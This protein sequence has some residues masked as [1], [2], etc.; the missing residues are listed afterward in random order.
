MNLSQSSKYSIIATPMKPGGT[1]RTIRNLFMDG[2][3]LNGFDSMW[4]LWDYTESIEKMEA[5]YFLINKSSEYLLV[6]SEIDEM[7]KIFPSMTRSRTVA[8]TVVFNDMET[9][10]LLLLMTK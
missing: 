10:A 4:S 3:L 1:P 6:T 9:A 5:R 7:C 8:A 2:G